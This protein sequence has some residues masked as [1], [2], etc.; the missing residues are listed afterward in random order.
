MSEDT[1][2]P[3]PDDLQIVIG[4]AVLGSIKSSDVRTATEDVS[5]SDAPLIENE[6]NVSPCC[7]DMKMSCLCSI[8]LRFII[9]FTL[10]FTPAI[11]TS[12]LCGINWVL[13]LGYTLWLYIMIAS[14]VIIPIIYYNPDPNDTRKSILTQYTIA[15]MI[16]IIVIPVILTL[17]LKEYLLDFPL[18][19]IGMVIDIIAV[20]VLV[21]VLRVGTVIIQY[22]MCRVTADGIK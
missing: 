3:T 14:V 16:N 2:V 9:V 8:L 7:W 19:W 6:T 11:V 12:T 15:I 18:P 4:D 22:Y 5:E 1:K 20:A 13:I 21:A 10:L 17:S